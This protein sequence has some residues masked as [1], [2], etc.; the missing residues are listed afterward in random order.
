[1]P[2]MNLS[3]KVLGWL[4]A[5]RSGHDYFADY[6][7][8]FGHEAEDIHCKCG[9]RRPRPHPSL[10]VDASPHRA[11]LSSMTERRPL[12]TRE[13]LGTTHGVRMFGEWAPITDLFQRKKGTYDE[14]AGL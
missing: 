6:H 10:C 5:A 2:V 4:I 8:R 3:R 14:L 1:M 7:D 9:Q 13:V 11:R 12:T